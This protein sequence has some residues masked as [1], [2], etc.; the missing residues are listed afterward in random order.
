LFVGSVRLRLPSP[1]NKSV[2]QDQGET[3]VPWG[4]FNRILLTKL[5]TFREDFTTDDFSF[6]SAKHLLEHIEYEKI[7]ITEIDREEAQSIYEKIPLNLRTEKFI[8]K[9][10]SKEQFSMLEMIS[11][12]VKE[13]IT[14]TKIKQLLQKVKASL[15]NVFETVAITS[16][17]TQH[18]S[19]LSMDVLIS[20]FQ[21]TDY[22]EIMSIVEQAKNL[23]ADANIALESDDSDQDYFQLRSHLF[24]YHV[25]RIL[26]NNF[27]ADYANIVRKLIY[28]VS[29][30]KIYKYYIFKKKAYDAKLFFSLFGKDAIELYDKIYL[31]DDSAY[32]LQQRAICK[33]MLNDIPSAFADIDKAISLQK[34]NFSIKNTRAII[35]FEA[36]KDIKSSAAKERLMEAMEILNECYRSD[37]R[38]VYHA[39]KFAEYAIFI[40]EHYDD[41]QYIAQAKTWLNNIIKT[42]DFTSHRTKYLIRELSKID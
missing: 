35:L 42:G 17:L 9:K 23:L 32:T 40:F 39:E 16:Y 4:I 1:T 27:R 29:P 13:F 6:E 7:E 5:G 20:Y 36:N 10:D 30:Y 15:Y 11:C 2:K 38:K 26:I 18:K 22:S 12:N 41:N 28:S 37:K 14:E 34:N 8:Y 25:H 19:A 21:T 31:R 3:N 33:L 24:A